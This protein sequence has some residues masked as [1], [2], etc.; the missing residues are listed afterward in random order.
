MSYDLDE[1]GIRWKEEGLGENLKDRKGKK[2]SL[3]EIKLIF[4]IKFKYYLE[5]EESIIIN[6]KVPNKII[7][8]PTIKTSLF[9]NNYF[10]EIELEF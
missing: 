9:E 10:L 8:I 5:N 7:E 3:E 1:K 2:D 4:S 6:C